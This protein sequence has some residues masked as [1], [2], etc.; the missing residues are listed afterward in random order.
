MVESFGNKL[1]GPCAEN[2]QALLIFPLRRESSSDDFCRLIRQEVGAVVYLST[3][4]V[5]YS[6]KCGRKLYRSHAYLA[7]ILLQC[8]AHDRC[9]CRFS[10]SDCSVF[11]LHLHVALKAKSGNTLHLS[12]SQQIPSKAHDEQVLSVYPKP[13]VKQARTHQ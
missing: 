6:F 10:S 4:W 1:V 3:C 12:C 2:F 9:I 5:I 11:C 8:N 13:G 7:L